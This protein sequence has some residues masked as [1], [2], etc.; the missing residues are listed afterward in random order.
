MTYVL[1]IWSFY[2][3][4]TMRYTFIIADS[5]PLAVLQHNTGSSDECLDSAYFI[6][7]LGL[8]LKYQQNRN[9]NQN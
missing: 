1:L 9:R 8:Q 7:I 5:L 3:D 2:N 6:A 4:W